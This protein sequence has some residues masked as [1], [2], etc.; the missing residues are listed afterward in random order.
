MTMTRT[1]WRTGV[2]LLGSLLGLA[3][4]PPSAARE[5]TLDERVAARKAIESVYWNHRIWPAENPGSKLPL[6]AI[7]SDAAV[8]AKVEYDLRMSSLL[9]R[10]WHEPVTGAMLQSEI[11]RMV[12][13]TKTPAT[14]RELFAA[15]HD[16]PA[17]IA[18]CLARPAVVNRK[19]AALFGSDPRIHGALRAALETKLAGIDDLA[20]LSRLPG[21]RA[22]RTIAA[23]DA[24]TWDG[25]ASELAEGF[26]L[27]PERVLQDIPVGR[28]SRLVDRGDRFAV[29]ALRAKD[30]QSATLVS[31]SWPKREL[32]DWSR[33]AMPEVE[34]QSAIEPPSAGYALPSVPEGASCVNGAWELSILTNAAGSN[35]PT[36]RQLHTALWTGA[37]MIVWGGWDGT[38][39]AY[40]NGGRYDP[41]TDSWTLSA[42]TTGT[43]AFV[44]A[45]RYRHTAIWTGTEMIV[46]GGITAGSVALNTGG[47]YNPA[48]DA[49]DN[50]SLTAATGANVPSPRRLHTA[51][52]TGTSMIVWGGSPSAGANAVKTGGVYDPSAD[53]WSLSVLT[54][55]A[56]S[57]TPSAR[58]E[59]SAVWTGSEMIVWG[60][61]DTSGATVKTGGR[62]DPAADTWSLSSLTSGTGTNVPSARYRHTAVWTGNAMIVWGGSPGSTG[63]GLNNGGRYNPGSDRWELTTLT[64]ATG[65]YVPTGRQLHSVVWT[66]A[67]MIVWGGSTDGTSAVLNTGGRYVPISD[68]WALSSLTNGT[69]SN[70]PAARQF[71]SAIWTGLADHRMIIWGGAP[72]TGTGGLYCAVCAPRLW[73]Q[74]ADG[75]GYG[76]SAVTQSSC[77]QPAGYVAKNGDCNDTAASIHPG[78]TEV[79]NGIDENCDTVI[80]NGGGAL[81]TDGL[82]CTADVCN[83]AAG[84]FATHASANF[85]TTTFSA[86]RVDGK[87]LVVLAVAWNSCPGDTLYNAAANLDQAGC[88]DLTDFHLFMTTFGQDCP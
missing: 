31:V 48:A 10:F 53:T 65:L 56:L 6:D 64:A 29:F 39:V 27:A 68:T 83:G 20:A 49:W 14:L 44:P 19:V 47:R 61:T 30:Q 74:D 88:I 43:D 54:S 36:P 18:E 70:V 28:V 26:Q 3:L 60:G 12:R 7:L 50:T 51:I 63:A 67:E 45:A 82:A 17:T 23:A 78:A 71:H 34:G 57:N 86:N 40:A 2:I 11:E 66:G 38:G 75:D 84:C 80:D 58:V 32:G 41:A 1:V 8:R 5:L 85:D 16:D 15:L 42:L 76:N 79:C 73:Y 33:Q 55:G 13:D 4:A 25:L 77:F 52:W 22:E 37:E 69:G 24:E 62:Y 35:R 59:H 21:D 87:D 81:C 46:W 72:N 9:E